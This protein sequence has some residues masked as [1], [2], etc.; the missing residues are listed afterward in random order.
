MYSILGCTTKVSNFSRTYDEME[1]AVG[2]VVTEGTE[3]FLNYWLAAENAIGADAQITLDLDCEKWINGV[4][5]R[6]T[7]NSY[8]NDRGTKNF[9]LFGF[10]ASGVLD[11]LTHGQLPDQR[12]VTGEW[13]QFFPLNT[14]VYVKFLKFQVDSFY[15]KGG[16]LHYILENEADKIGQNYS[17]WQLY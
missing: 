14:L 1:E 17:G 9:T 5:I 4:Y 8:L 10:N 2:F 11:I 3:Y 12:N 7:H 15:G 13:T 6:N 16:G